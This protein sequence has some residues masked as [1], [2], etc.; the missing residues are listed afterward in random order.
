MSGRPAVFVD[1]DGTLIVEK[2]YLSDPAE[3]ELIAGAGEALRRLAEAGYALVVITNQSGIARGRFTA[4]DYERVQQRVRELLA[5]QG[6]RLDGVYYCPHHPDFTGPCDCRKPGLE[7]YQRAARDLGLDLE[8]SICVGDRI[9]DV[10]PARR[11]RGRAV[12]V[13]T[14]YG[15]GEAA[16]G[17]PQLEIVADMRAAADLILGRGGAGDG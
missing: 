5:A 11:F 16:R 8:R 17:W 1:R 14:G 13:R 9:A 10:E 3:V 2:H 6:V 15:A 4:A 7:L 12:L